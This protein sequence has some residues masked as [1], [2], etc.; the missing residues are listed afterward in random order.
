MMENNQYGNTENSTNETVNTT[1]TNEASG[2]TSGQQESGS[3]YSYSYLNQDQKNPNNVWRAEEN[4]AGSYTGNSAYTNTQ[5]NAG[6]AYGNNQ[7]GTNSAYGS[8]TNTGNVYGSNQTGANSAYG[9]GQT[10]PGGAYNNAQYTA[11]G[12]QTGTDIWIEKFKN[13]YSIFF[14]VST[15]LIPILILFPVALITIVTMRFYEVQY[16]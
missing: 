1:N 10:N 9:S 12:T 5:A 2:S 4:T 11:G 15:K 16:I 14:I 8:Q 7:A 3:T 6:N 13:R